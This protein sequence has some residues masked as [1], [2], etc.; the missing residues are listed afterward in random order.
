MI[1]SDVT[2]VSNRVAESKFQD[3]R[4]SSFET[5]TAS[6]DSKDTASTSKRELRGWLSYGMAAE[7]FAVCGVGQY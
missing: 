1:P 7:V 3:G 2:G 4:C 6:I 5:K